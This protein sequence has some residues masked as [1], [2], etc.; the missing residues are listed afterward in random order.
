MD[1]MGSC[2]HF[3]TQMTQTNELWA[4][5]RNI[6]TCKQDR[7]VIV[8]P[9]H[10][11]VAAFPHIFVNTGC[12]TSWSLFQEGKKIDYSTLKCRHS[13]LNSFPV[14]GVLA[15]INIVYV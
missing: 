3:H 2:L 8:L 7:R 11:Y 14:S 10:K 5:I 1:E 4:Q 12:Y 15:N 6:S 13:D 9:F